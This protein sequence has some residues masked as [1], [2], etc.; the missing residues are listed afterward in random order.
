MDDVV[1]VGSGFV[2]VGAHAGHPAAWTSPD[3][4]TWLP[5]TVE[6][7]PVDANGEGG[8]VMQHVVAGPHGL[9]AIG[10]GRD[11][12]IGPA[13]WVSPDGLEWTIAVDPLPG[14]M[15]VGSPNAE[16]GP[17][18]TAWRSTDAR[19]WKPV[20]DITGTWLRGFV[21][22]RGGIVAVGSASNA[23]TDLEIPAIWTMTTGGVWHR[24]QKVPGAGH[25]DRD[26][27]LVAVTATPDHLIATGPSPSGGIGIWI[28][29]DG[30][31]WTRTK[32]PGLEGP[33]GEFE[34]T[35]IAVAGDGVV[36]VGDFPNGDPSST[37]AAAVWT[38]PAPEQ[39][40]G[41]KPVA[42]AHPCPPGAATLVDVAEMTSTER[43]ACFGRHDLALRGY[44]G[45]FGDGGMT[46]FP[47]TPGWLA[48]D[49]SCCR[50]LL[51]LAGRPQD[52]VFLP[53]AFDPAAPRQSKF[54]D[55][56]AIQVTGHFD[57]RRAT[58]CREDG[59]RAARSILA[60]RQRFV[61]TSVTRI[62]RP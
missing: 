38:D 40:A 39:P 36:V 53:V 55:G 19:H 50:P 57:D 31:S 5:S 32:S 44:L 37:W 25:N 26:V 33:E 42:V 48:D 20:A 45:G 54:Q 14:F 15:I 11:S 34:P 49:T 27:S 28:S 51:P 41:P 60:C 52:I 12:Q 56:A 10:T 9:A 62:D 7:P 4:L 13:V 21:T 43:L 35:D 59:V 1:A 22:W 58:S 8:S 30:T 46:A 47:A 3:G 29:T 18:I 24:V 2:A 16:D 61:V 23:E 6:T 17:P